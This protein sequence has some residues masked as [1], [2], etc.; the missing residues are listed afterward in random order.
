MIGRGS[1]LGAAARARAP[2]GSAPRRGAVVRRERAHEAVAV[3]RHEIEHQ[4]RRLAA[5]RRPARTPCRSAPA[6]RQ[7]STMR[8]PPCMTRPKRNALTSPRPVSPVLRRQLEGHLRQVDHH[9]V[10]IGEREGA[11]ID[12]AR[13]IHDEAGLVVVAAD[14]GVGRDRKLAAAGAGAAVRARPSGAI[15]APRQQHKRD[16]R[17]MRSRRPNCHESRASEPLLLH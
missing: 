4:P 5:R 7:S 1:P 15:P 12:L 11:Q 8:E 6:C 13:E 16:A 14:P 9:A 10:G 3:G 17:L 2:A